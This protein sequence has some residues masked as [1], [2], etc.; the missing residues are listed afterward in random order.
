MNDFKISTNRKGIAYCLLTRDNRYMTVTLNDQT[1]K[2]SKEISK[3]K[4]TL[5]YV[6]KKYNVYGVLR[7]SAKK[8]KPILWWLRKEIFEAVK[9][10]VLIP[11]DKDSI[12]DISDKGI[13]VFNGNFDKNAF[14]LARIAADERVNLATSFDKFVEALQKPKSTLVV[15]GGESNVSN[16]ASE[17]K[18]KDV[19][20]KETTTA[21]K[22]ETTANKVEADVEKKKE[23]VSIKAETTKNKAVDAVVE[24]ENKEVK[25]TDTEVKEDKAIETEVKATEK[26]V[27][28][29][30]TEDTLSEDKVLLKS[31]AAATISLKDTIK[32]I[33]QMAD[34]YRDT[35]SKVSGEY[36]FDTETT[37]LEV[38]SMV[39]SSD[40]EIEELKS[41]DYTLE[42]AMY[43]S[44]LKILK[45]DDTISIP[46]RYYNGLV[47]VIKRNLM[48]SRDGTKYDSIV[49]IR[50]NRTAKENIVARVEYC[51]SNEYCRVSV[52]KPYNI[53][54]L[55][56]QQIVKYEIEFN[57]WRKLHSFRTAQ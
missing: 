46:T 24:T 47:T 56:E 45:T 2:E 6:H 50:L 54:D 25:A 15:H 9:D 18:E 43:E 21:K 57:Q 20:K 30:N 48:V 11:E 7:D 34:N 51:E 35:L 40:T 16:N 44:I 55:S 41:K 19:D 38:C 1:A 26:E 39:D 36:S 31:L 22:V 37:A 12:R 52:I 23:A 53:V 13:E 28:N 32:E 10:S 8:A 3:Y 17:K 5:A 4:Y 27:S 33:K 29:S 14:S 42:D 49:K